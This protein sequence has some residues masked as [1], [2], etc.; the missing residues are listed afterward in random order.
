[1]FPRGGELAQLG[2]QHSWRRRCTRH[3]R[4]EAVLTGHLG[5]LWLSVERNKLHGHDTR[6]PPAAAA[7]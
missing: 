4:L 2:L 6:R 7:V 3:V 5:V 1:M